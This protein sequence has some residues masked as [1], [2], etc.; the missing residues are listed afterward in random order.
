MCSP[1]FG[2]GGSR[3][4]GLR[5]AIAGCVTAL[6]GLLL[7]GTCMARPALALPEGR[8]Y[9]MV[10]PL[11]KGG[12]GAAPIKAVAP[13]GES[14]V[15]ASQG[16]FAGAPSS[17]GLNEYLARR[18]ATGWSTVPLMA[19]ATISPSVV[20]GQLS[21]FSA[22]LDTSLS[23]VEEP[24]SNL[25]RAGADRTESVFLL[26]R[27]DAPDVAGNF[28]VAGKVLTAL[29]GVQFVPAY[30]GASSDFSHILFHTTGSEALLSAAAGGAQQLYDLV[31]SGAGAP[32]LRLVGL[33]DKDEL[34]DGGYCPTLLGGE[35]TDQN[36]KFNAISA[37]GSEIFFVTNANRAEGQNCDS[38]ADSTTSGNPRIVYVRIDGQSTLQLSAPLATGC[39]VSAPCHS[40]AQASAEFMGANEAGSCAFFMTTQPLVTGDVDSGRDLYM[41]SIGRSGEAGP[42][43]ERSGNGQ[44]A[45]EMTSLVQVS[46]AS[47][48]EDAEVQGVVSIS[49]NGGRVY[50]VARG[51]LSENPN[52]EGDVAVKGADNLYVYDTGS[53]GAPTF[54]A[55]LCSASEA[56]GESRD[57]ACPSGLSQH[58]ESDAAVWRN[59]TAQ[60]ADN[61]RFLLFPSYGQ[62]LPGDTDTA[63]DIYRY[64]AVTGTLDRI[65]IGEAGYDANGNND[66][67]D[68]T[69]PAEESEGLVSVKARLGTRAISEDG[70]RILFTTAESLSPS[71]VNGLANEYE[72][73]KA[74]GS[75]EA[76]VSLIST[77]T[78]DEPVDEAVISPSGRDIFFVTSQG[79]VP[80]DTDNAPD[81]FDARLGGGF[82]AP[83]AA[84]QP[85]S[86]DACQGPLSTPTALLVPGS[87]A[88]DAGGN[89]STPAAKPVAKA[90]SRLK[91]RPKAGRK[92]KAGQR[93][94]RR[95]KTTTAHRSGRARKSHQGGV[96]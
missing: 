71:A 48:G 88:Q 91:R 82:P 16:A 1:I 24:G 77:G 81:V 92:T 96:R 10:S 67:F 18:T 40:A 68:A 73:H 62:L 80:Q 79:L 31:T 55:D 65:S 54:I 25:G 69:I 19:P 35:E 51:V 93:P 15:F 42:T 44:G 7:G 47:P 26:H 85:C 32:S 43:C 61:G 17:P 29:G 2:S 14:V 84:R 38:T 86:G 95:R 37:D 83:P 72:W 41:A 52:A 13:D 94:R 30:L 78:S 66:A 22:T 49:P 46:H 4:L 33:N 76:V 90:K 5:R 75:S 50:F 8:V 12:Y 53:G 36:S 60:Q 70:T 34:I 58:G 23:E 59:W 74:T 87:L 3:P 56:S 6:A 21:D 11:Y 28:E 9:E 45:A 64:D 63:S 57:P 20:Q 27:S 89:F 39:A